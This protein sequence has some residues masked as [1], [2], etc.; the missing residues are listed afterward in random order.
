MLWS[1]CDTIWPKSSPIESEFLKSTDTSPSGLAVKRSQCQCHVNAMFWTSRLLLYISNVILSWEITIGLIC[2][3]SSVENHTWFEN[4][5]V[6]K[7]QLVSLT[8]NAVLIQANPMQFWSK[9]IWYNFICCNFDP[10]DVIDDK[11]NVCDND[12]EMERSQLL[13]KLPM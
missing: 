11:D 6:W 10:Q 2:T 8:L 1:T 13:S 7:P 12:A 9:P 5:C 3:S 4:S